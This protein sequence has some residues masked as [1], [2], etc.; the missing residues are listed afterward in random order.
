[1]KQRG[2]FHH[3]LKNLHVGLLHA[4]AAQAADVVDGLFHVAAD[5]AVAAEE[6]VVLFAHL[7]AKDACLNGKGDFACTGRL[8]TVAD[9][10]RCDAQGILQGVLDDTERLTH[11]V[12][13]AAARGATC[14]D[15]TAIG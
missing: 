6:V 8:G 14:T 4:I 3:D 7:I 5:D 9:D 15:G 11:E 13:D 2:L 12:G 10:A 1:M